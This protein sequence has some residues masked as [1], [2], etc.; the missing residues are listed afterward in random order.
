[1]EKTITIDGQDVPLKVTA[2]CV[3]MYKA[4]F[5]RDLMRDIW[6]FKQFESNIENGELKASDDVIAKVDFEVFSNLLW[7]FAKKA[8]KSVPNPDDF[9]DRFTSIPF[10]I[11]LPEIMDLLTVLLEGQQ[12][13]K[14][15]LA[16]VAK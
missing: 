14:K 2:N 15:H 7:V 5:R 1:M 10:R 3:R 16:A 8:D 12:S 13:G 6:Q 11:V 4:Q 9:E